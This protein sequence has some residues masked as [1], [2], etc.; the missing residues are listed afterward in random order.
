MTEAKSFFL[1][2]RNLIKA[3]IFLFFFERI[4]IKCFV[5]IAVFVK[6]VNHEIESVLTLLRA[7]A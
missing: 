3:S 2:S 1:V 4:K 7:N 5:V 6:H